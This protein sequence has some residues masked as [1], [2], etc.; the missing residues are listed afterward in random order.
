MTK[1][2]FGLFLIISPVLV[3]ADVLEE[4]EAQD[5]TQVLDKAKSRS[6]VKPEGRQIVRINDKENLVREV[7]LK[8]VEEI[9]ERAPA[10]EE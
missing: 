8:E 5:L 2:I 3:C 4:S 10:S 9:E 7:E 6:S 1:F